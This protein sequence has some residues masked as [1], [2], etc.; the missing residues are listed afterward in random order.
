VNL[1]HHSK[2]TGGEGVTVDDG[3]GASALLASVRSAR[4]I[5]TMTKA[6][7]ASAQVSERDRRFYSA[8]TSARPISPRQ[9]KPLT[10]SSLFLSTLA[11]PGDDGDWHTGDHV[12]VVTAWR[13]PTIAMPVIT[14]ADIKRA[15]EAVTNGGPWRY[16]Q[17][18]RTEQW[19]G[20]PIAQVLSLD[21]ENKLIKKAVATMVDAWLQEGL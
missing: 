1:V 8:P 4:S 9:R 5:N 3:R 14:N 18:S 10:G 15:Q 20:K 19:I 6:E 7:A 16:D 12:G 21:L 17:Q 11:I 2:K 13:Y